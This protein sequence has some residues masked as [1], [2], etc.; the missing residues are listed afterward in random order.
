MKN[1]KENVHGAY[2]DMRSDT[3]TPL[4]L[5]E[6]LMPLLRDYFFCKTEICGGGLKIEFPDGQK[7]MLVAEK[8]GGAP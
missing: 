1:L 6:E 2:A 4:S 5:A 3:V 7:F 8:T